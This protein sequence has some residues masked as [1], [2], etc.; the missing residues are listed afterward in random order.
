MR[1]GEVEGGRGM[2]DELDGGIIRMI[3][4]GRGGGRK[5]LHVRDFSNNTSVS[6]RRLYKGSG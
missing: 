5:Q 1:W 6:G 4:R 2:T 3:L